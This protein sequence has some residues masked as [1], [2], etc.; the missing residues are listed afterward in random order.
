MLRTRYGTIRNITRRGWSD[1]AGMASVGNADDT[2]A[3][4]VSTSPGLIVDGKHNVLI[5]SPTKTTKRAERSPPGRGHHAGGIRLELM[6]VQTARQ[7]RAFSVR[8]TCGRRHA[9]TSMLPIR[10]TTRFA[11]ITAAGVR[12]DV[13]GTAAR[14]SADGLGSVAR[15]T[16]QGCGRHQRQRCMSQT[17]AT[18]R[19]QDQSRG[20]VTNAR[21]TAA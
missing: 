2:A 5:M 8:K 14:G 15:L 12:V 7:C 16:A 9:A 17:A 20:F 18:T 13:A 19:F 6:V 10:T 3:P 4:P 11:E 1:V 21:K